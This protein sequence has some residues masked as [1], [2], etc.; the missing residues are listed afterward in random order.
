MDLS[1]FF[2][3]NLH[4]RLD[5]PRVGPLKCK[6]QLGQIGPTASHGQDCL[7]WC[8]ADP[9]Q[10]ER[11]CNYPQTWKLSFCRE[12]AKSGWMTTV[13]VRINKSWTEGRQQRQEQWFIRDWFHKT[14]LILGMGDSWHIRDSPHS[15]WPVMPKIVHRPGWR[16]IADHPTAVFL[17][18]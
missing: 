18:V 3:K 12:E 17:C 4:T 11:R 16:P 9:I 6:Y 15:L 13:A 2:F 10:V 8:W 7:A 14:E 1:K 5:Y